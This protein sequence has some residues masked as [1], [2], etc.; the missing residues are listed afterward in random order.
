MALPLSELD[1]S[2]RSVFLVAVTLCLVLALGLAF[3]FALVLI[4]VRQWIAVLIL[5]R[6][7]LNCVR[8]VVPACRAALVGV[9]LLCSRR[10]RNERESTQSQADSPQ[11]HAL[12]LNPVP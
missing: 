3:V 12:L 2:Y 5:F 1:D 6:R 11:P 8:A 4:V 10:D 9:A 7:Q